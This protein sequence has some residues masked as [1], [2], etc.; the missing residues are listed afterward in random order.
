M[1]NWHTMRVL[2]S[3][4]FRHFS[5]SVV[6]QGDHA[7]LLRWD[8]SSTVVTAAFDYHTNPWSMA[9][10]LWRFDHLSPRQRGHNQSI[11]PANL[12]PRSTRA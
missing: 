6:I 1:G 7:R 9:E 12:S 10:F 5:F 8:L 2:H 3:L 11:Q 4:Q